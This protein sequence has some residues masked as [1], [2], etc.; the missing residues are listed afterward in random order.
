M[1]P[2]KKKDILHEVLTSTVRDNLPGVEELS[3]FLDQRRG[4]QEDRNLQPN[5]KRKKGKPGKKKTTHYL[6][7]ET[8]E[9]LNR[10][11]P[12]IRRIFPEDL[13]SQLSKSRL[14]DSSMRLL[15]QEFEEKGKDSL[16]VRQF[17]D[18]DDE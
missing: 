2:G 7:L 4:G 18:D 13:R 3:N 10:T 8:F 15:L 5:R 14:V 12:R 1:I 6:S 11:L 9:C 17:L 16:L